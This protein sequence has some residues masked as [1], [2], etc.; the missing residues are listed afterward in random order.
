V[1][2]FNIILKKHGDCV[3][4]SDVEVD[5]HDEDCG[6]KNEKWVLFFKKPLNTQK[7]KKRWFLIFKIENKEKLFRIQRRQEVACKK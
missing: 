3:C 2:L 4:I 6:K 7:D 1:H 5:Y